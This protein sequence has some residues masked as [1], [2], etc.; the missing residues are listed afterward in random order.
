MILTTFVTSIYV[1]RKCLQK[2]KNIKRNIS[3]SPIN[4]AP[5]SQHLNNTPWNPELVT[6]KNLLFALFVMLFVG[7]AYTLR[8]YKHGLTEYYE[9]MFLRIICNDILPPLCL[10]FIVPLTLYINNPSLQ[11]FFYE[12]IIKM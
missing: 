2:Y 1:T 10:S 3:V 6:S 8:F 4:Q 12:N 9:K 7:V 11:T 5:P